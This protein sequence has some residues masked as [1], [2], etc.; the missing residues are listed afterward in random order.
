MRDETIY[1]LINPLRQTVQQIVNW[2]N[3][4]QNA[5]RLDSTGKEIRLLAIQRLAIKKGIFTEAEMTEMSGEVIKEMQKQAE[6]EAAKAQIVPATPA[7]TAAVNETKTEA[8]AST[9]PTPAP[10][11]ET[12]ATPPAQA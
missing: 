8:T 2:V 6:E 12:P 1:G 9:T 4:F 5:I 11:A 10:A 3:N 7:Q